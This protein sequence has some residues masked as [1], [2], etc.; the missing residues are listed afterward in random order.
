MTAEEAV[1][2]AR[3]IKPRLAIPMHYGAIV[4]SENDAAQFKK[5]LQGEVEVVILAKAKL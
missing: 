3:T 1:L 2:A 5:A 4:G